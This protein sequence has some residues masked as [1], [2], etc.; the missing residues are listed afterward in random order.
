MDIKQQQTTWQPTIFDIFPELDPDGIGLD[1]YVETIEPESVPNWNGWQNNDD[2]DD[3]SVQAV[4]GNQQ[5]DDGFFTAQD[6][7]DETM[8]AIES[9]L[10]P[11]N[12]SGIEGGRRV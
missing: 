11:W 12:A 5:A 9:Q 3:P 1:P 2:E 8:A 7:Y 4:I 10:R 6:E